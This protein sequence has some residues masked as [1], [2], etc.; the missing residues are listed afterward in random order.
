MSGMPDRRVCAVVLNYNQSAAA[1][2]AWDELK[3]S[4]GIDVD[5]L[6]VDAASA[7]RDRDELRSHVPADRLLLLAENLGYAGGMNAGIRF[8]HEHAPGAAILLV[9][10]DAR[11]PPDLALALWQALV[12]DDT[13]G[14]VGPVV[15][16]RESPPRIGAGGRVDPRRARVRLIPEV[17]AT[18]P[19]D[20]DWIEGCCIML[21]P[22]ALLDVGGFDEEYFL[23]FEEVDLCHRLRR[24]GWRVRV[25]PTARVRHPKA[26]G[27][28]PAH[29]YYYMT[30]NGYRFWARNFGTATGLAAMEPLRSTLWLGALALGSVLLPTRW[31]EVPDRWRDWRLQ[32]RGAWAGTRDHLRGRYG[33][34][35]VSTPPRD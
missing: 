7:P 20:A 29:Y 24:A 10:P 9:T 11:L 18:T 5:V 8:W 4:Q 28:L 22:R 16:Y 14:A 30:R 35:P 32:L 13:I 3:R 33:R 23:Y 2:Q 19:Y 34:G 15:V 31:R 6:V 25:V 1:C 17:R 12:A 26:S 21:R 27:R